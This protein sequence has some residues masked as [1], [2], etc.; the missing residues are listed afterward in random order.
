MTTSLIILISTHVFL[1]VTAAIAFYAL[2]LQLLAKRGTHKKALLWRAVLGFVSTA[3]SEFISVVYLSDYY[4]GKLGLI[5]NQDVT[6]L[7]PSLVLARFL[8]L[9]F[10]FASALIL[11]L[12]IF[13]KGG[14]LQ[15]KPKYKKVFIPLAALSCVAAAALMFLGV[16][17]P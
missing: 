7:I 2:L 17:I 1:L 3:V 15:E 4:L 8:L 11:L 13:W 16:L 14:Q 6:M 5:T 10:L 9:P 12:G